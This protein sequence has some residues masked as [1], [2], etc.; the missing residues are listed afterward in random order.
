MSMPGAIHQKSLSRHGASLRDLAL[1]DL[2]AER[3]AAYRTGDNF[4]F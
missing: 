3:L 2:T 1:R 4:G